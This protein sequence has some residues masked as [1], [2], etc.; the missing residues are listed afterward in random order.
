VRAAAQKSNARYERREGDQY[1]F[2][3]MAG[4][5]SGPSF[6]IVLASATATIEVPSGSF[7]Q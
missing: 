5:H 1:V 2:V 4:T 3:G 6:P 7:Q